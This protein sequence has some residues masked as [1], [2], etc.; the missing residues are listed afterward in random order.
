MS[1]KENTVNAANTAIKTVI[2][3]TLGT[4]GGVGKSTLAINLADFFV[5]LNIPHKLVDMD[6]ENATLSRFYPEAERRNPRRLTEKDSLVTEFAE[7]GKYALVLADLRAGSGD[8]MLEWFRDVPFDYLKEQGIV[9]TAYGLVTSDPDSVSTL[10]HWA[11]TIG[12][13]V[14]YIVVKNQKDGPDFPALDKTVEGEKF[15]QEFQPGI[16]TIRSIPP[17]IMSKLNAR[18]LTFAKALTHPETIKAVND[19][20]MRGRLARWQKELFEQFNAHKDLILGV[21]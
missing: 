11:R 7:S 1:K 8:E 9:F 20:M 15:L 18:N 6:D 2:N 17:D 14:R 5:S 21:E 3:I 4:K 13:S 10:L 19:S 12:H 16:V